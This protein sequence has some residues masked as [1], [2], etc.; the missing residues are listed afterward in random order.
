MI[1][2]DRGD[3]VVDA[4]ARVNV[5]AECFSCPTC[6]LVLDGYEL[7]ERANLPDTFETIDDNPELAELDY[8][9]D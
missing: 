6:H 5:P 8:G 4:W 3:G 9:N 7:I 1:E 2:E